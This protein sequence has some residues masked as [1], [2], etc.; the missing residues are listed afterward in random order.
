MLL[1]LMAGVVGAHRPLFVEQETS[2]EQPEIIPDPDVSWAV[3][4]ELEPGED[5]DY[6][7]FTVPEGGLEFFT[8]LLVPHRREFADFQPTV[9]L[10]GAGLPSIESEVPFAVPQDTGAVTI[11]WQDKE[12]FFEPFT[13]TRY[14]MA[15]EFRKHLEAGTWYLAVYHPQ[16][17]GGKYTLA[18]GEREDWAWQDIFAFP[19]MWFRTRW[20]Y[21]PGQTIAILAIGVGLLGLVWFIKRR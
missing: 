10:I 5:V 1:I 12:I 13:Q 9:A 19:G 2:I 4:A 17:D 14:Y 18:V 3:Y 15:Q 7:Q 20:W 16:G 8:Q 11:P 6:Y 21:S